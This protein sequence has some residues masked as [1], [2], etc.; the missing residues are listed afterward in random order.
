MTENKLKSLI[1]EEIKV[2]M[3][4]GDKE[5]TTTLRM[6]ISEIKK[7]EID[8][9]TDLNEENTISII[10]KMIKQRKDSSNQ[11]RSANRDELA[12]KEEMEIKFLTEFLPEQIS[13]EE[14]T[15]IVR[16]TIIREG[17]SSPQDM[18]K[19]MGSLKSNLQGKADMAVVSKVV[20]KSLNK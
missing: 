17:A 18:G 4:K 13:E 10:Q 8:K 5:K 20:K 11:F 6:A 9:Q 1:Q 19:I 7:E 15:E 2:S 16:E 12:A 3:K 14:I